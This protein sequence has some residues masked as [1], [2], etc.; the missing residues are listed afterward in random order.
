MNQDSKKVIAL[1]SSNR[2]ERENLEAVKIGGFSVTNRVCDKLKA[3]V[4]KRLISASMGIANIQRAPRAER[5]HRCKE[6][7]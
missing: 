2:D 5:I 3:V 7:F 6:V 4:I 1:I